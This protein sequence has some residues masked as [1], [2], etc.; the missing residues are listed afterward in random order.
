VQVPSAVAEHLAR[1][2]E[3]PGHGLF[4]KE[5]RGNEQHRHSRYVWIMAT[6][7]CHTQVS[8]PT[9][10]SIVAKWG[11]LLYRKAHSTTAGALTLFIGPR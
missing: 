6:G 9:H 3:R 11:F 8:R 7:Y 5:E 10:E 2:F 1:A 4:D